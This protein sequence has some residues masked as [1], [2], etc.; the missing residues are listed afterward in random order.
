MLGPTMRS[1]AD[2]DW[3]ALLPDDRLTGWLSP[4]PDEKRM[5]IDPLVGYPD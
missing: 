5:T 3:A 4:H 1:R 2:L